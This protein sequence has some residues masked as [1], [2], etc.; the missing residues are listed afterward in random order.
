M[1][2]KYT[3]VLPMIDARNIATCLACALPQCVYEVEDVEYRALCPVWR[4]ERGEINTHNRQTRAR[5]REMEAG[6]A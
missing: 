4:R 3:P 1:P 6:R 5:A 2:S